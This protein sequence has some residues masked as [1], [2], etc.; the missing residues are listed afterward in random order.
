MKYFNILFLI[1]FLTTSAKA[2]SVKVSVSKVSIPTYT[3]PE[4]EELPMFAENRVHQRSSGNPYPNKIVL[5]VNREQKVDKEYTLIKLENE[6]LELQILPEIG[7]KIYAAKDK[8]NGYDFFYKNHVIKPALIG[9]LGSWISGG[10]EF[11]WPFHHRA[12]SFMPTDYE[13]EK[14]PGGGV[15]VWVSEHDPTDRMKGMVGIVLNPG[16]SIFETRVKLS[17]ITPLRHSFLWWEN[18]AVP[19]NKNYEIFFPHD[20]SHVFFHY[21]RSVTTYPVATNAAGIF[22]GIRYDG[23]VDISKHKNTIQPTSYFSAASQYDFFGGYDTGR[24]CGVV[25]IG[26]HHVSPGKKMFTWA[27]NQL[28]QSWE[29]ALTD[30][31]GAYCELMAGSYSDNQ[32]DFT[33]LEPMETKTFS[34]YWFPIGEIGVPDFANTT[35]AIYVKDT[36]KVQLNK[37]R[38]VKI[39]VK[40]DNQILYSGKATV[41]AREE[42]MLPADVRM[43]LGYSIDVTANDGTVLMS[44]TVKKH[45]TFNIPHTTQDM[46][47]IKKV[48]SPH[49][50]YLEGLHV[51]QYRDP[52]T[53]GE[54]YYKEALERD[55]NFAPALIALGEAK[56]RN[57]FYSEALE[58]LLRAEKVLIRFNTRLENGKLYY[59]LG[60]VY[61]ALDEQEKSYDY[62]RKAAWSSA[63]VSSAMTYAAMLDIR[64]LEYDKAVQ[65]LTTAITY[66]KDNAVANALMIYASYLQ[67][68]KKASE[69]QYLSVEANDK[70]NHLARY[71]GVLSGKVSARDFMEKIRTDKN[72]VC[73]DLIET[74]LVANL[75]KETVSLIEMLQTHEP[76][77]F[78]LSA[79][80]ADIK[81]G[82]PN[83]SATEGIAFPSR[84][85]E[86]NSLSHWAKQGSRK[87]QLLLGCA[88]YAKGHYE[89]AVALWEGLSG[90]DYRAA[91]NLAVAY[92]SHMDRKNEVLPLLKQALSLKPNDEQLIFETVYVMGKL[93]VAPIER[94]SFL[95]NHKSVISRDDIMLEW[96]RAYNMAGQEDKAIELLRGRNFVPA[97]G[98]EHAVAEQYMFAYFLKG[99]RLMKENKMQEAT[100]CFK[101]AQ[102]L[103]QNLGAGLWNIVRLVPFK[104][105]EAIC[106][107]SLGQED[108]ANENFDFITG[109]EVDYF[110]NMNLP[111]LPFY[112]ALC[113]RETGMPFK[114]DM[115]INYKLQ[116]WKEGMKTIDAGY[117]ATTPFFISFCDRAVQQRSAYYSYLL[118]LAYRY[119]GDTKLAQKYIEQAAVSDPYALN[120]FAERQF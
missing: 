10:L 108:K 105:Y 40:G 37:T 48:E 8:T 65:H 27:Y 29:N 88:L 62:F 120:I 87:A 25:H 17:N 52:A 19:S 85:I 42:Y 33:W 56:L 35:G 11:N 102:T 67:G 96:A 112:Q 46:P 47:N 83:D 114:G 74:L 57:A 16:E 104:Y 38:N 119:T 91:R 7:G 21:K 78:S 23:A 76:L 45:D 44:Y 13:I 15:I 18:V 68:D 77:I 111:E 61:L 82:S 107:K 6:Y 54:S 113:Y 79:I 101:A 90:T 110:S 99:R 39:T 75:Q 80:Y 34:Q 28:S 55:P 41:K 50:L 43:K 5:K 93:G 2:Q 72:Q 58:Y 66:H 20:V 103:P 106:L 9:A 59:L 36:I 4:R 73:L 116:D 81:G 30:T 63:Y 86:M 49:L 94:I 71:F 97:E 84:R 1:L 100:D 117:F 12:S 26:D 115:L 64:K 98:G 69:R 53:K 95:N 60:H 24:K 31:D 70:L 51:D 14:L 89:K 3:E 22:N 32:P 92:Y 109:I 118:A